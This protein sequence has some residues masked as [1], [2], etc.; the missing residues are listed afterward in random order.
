MDAPDAHVPG[1]T[2]VSETA[3]RTRGNVHQR[4]PVRAPGPTTFGAWWQASSSA[5]AGQAAAALQYRMNTATYGMYDPCVITL[6]EVTG[7]QRQN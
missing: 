1:G 5:E 7:V 3:E 4:G 2:T 6:G